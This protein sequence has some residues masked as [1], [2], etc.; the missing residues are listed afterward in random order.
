MSLIVWVA[1]L[2]FVFSMVAIDLGVFHRRD[3]VPT[4]RG[5]LGWTLFWVALALIFNAVVFL[6][7]ENNYG[8]ASVPTEHLSGREAASEFFVAYVLEKSL[9]VDNIFVIAMIFAYFR[10]PP[11]E[12]HRVLFWGVLGAV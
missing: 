5:A 9:S 2:V 12:Q 3:T 4:V 1:F 7:Y 11:K 10:V 8:W 6:L